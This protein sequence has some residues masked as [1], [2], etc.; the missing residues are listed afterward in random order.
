MCAKAGPNT[1]A[2][3][4]RQWKCTTSILEALAEELY[5][6]LEQGLERKSNCIPMNNLMTQVYTT[7][8][9]QNE[10]GV[11]MIF[12]LRNPVMHILV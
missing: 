7:A 4:S 12:W 9:F 10:T 2:C 1:D 11:R 5:T 6:S 3:Y 8:I